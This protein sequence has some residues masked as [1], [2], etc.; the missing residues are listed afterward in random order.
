ME[1]NKEIADAL[2]V[3][4]RY[5]PGKVIR[6]PKDDLG[7][8]KNAVKTAIYADL[9][10]RLSMGRTEFADRIVSYITNAE[11]VL[12]ALA[13]KY[14]PPEDSQRNDLPTYQFVSLVLETA[15]QLIKDVGL[16][17]R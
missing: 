7:V 15:A 10:N 16:L 13:E 4:A 6:V 2:N 3:L 9:K 17:P 1:K 8:L 11:N 5:I 12:K 14:S